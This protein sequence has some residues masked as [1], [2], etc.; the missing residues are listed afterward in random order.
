MTSK[1]CCFRATSRFRKV[2]PAWVVA[3]SPEVE[4]DSCFLERSI[5][6]PSRPPAPTPTPLCHYYAWGARCNCWRA[7]TDAVAVVLKS[8]ACGAARPDC[9]G[10]CRRPPAH[11]PLAPAAQSWSG[12]AEC[13]GLSFGLWGWLWWS[14]PRGWSSA[15]HFWCWATCC[16]F[17]TSFCGFGT[18]S[19]SAFLTNK[20]RG[21]FRCDAGGSSNDWSGTLFPVLVFGDGYRRCVAFWAPC[22]V[23]SSHC[24]QKKRLQKK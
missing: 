6:V 19:W 13:R 20:G 23:E 17:C 12:W 10:V 7:V 15:A 11:A 18:R 9:L 1:F 21:Q 16:P 4:V 14:R 2:A 24:C 8:G 5:R 22:P 3:L